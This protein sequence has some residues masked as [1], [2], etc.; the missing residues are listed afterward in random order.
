MAYDFSAL[1]AAIKTVLDAAG[2]Q[3]VTLGNWGDFEGRHFS[4]ALKNK[5]YTIIISGMGASGDELAN[6]GL[7]NVSIEFS[8]DTANDLYIGVLGAA[9]AAIYSL[10]D[11]SVSTLCGVLNDGDLANFT[12]IIIPKGDVSFGSMVVQFANINVSVEVS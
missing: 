7:V 1:H 9:V 11:I 10:K 2:F 3:Y 8:M 6:S 4:G 12:S 5:G